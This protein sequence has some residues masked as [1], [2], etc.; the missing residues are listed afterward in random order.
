[1]DSL[2][3][4]KIREYAEE[5]F[6][7]TDFKA[8]I[9]KGHLI[10]SPF[11]KRVCASIKKDLETKFPDKV[12]QLPKDSMFQRSIKAALQNGSTKV[13]PIKLTFEDKPRAARGQKR[14]I[15][16]SSSEEDEAS[17][18]AST[19]DQ[20]ESP[21]P[22]SSQESSPVTRS[23]AP[24]LEE[25]AA[26]RLE[27]EQLRGERDALQAKVDKFMDL[28]LVRRLPTR[29]NSG[30]AETFGP[31]LQAIALEPMATGAAAK[32]VREVLFSVARHLDML[33]DE[34]YRV[35]QL[36]WFTRLRAKQDGLLAKQREQFLAPERGRP[37]PS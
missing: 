17:P 29:G 28:F 4:A 19:S 32:H 33:P 1:M 25:N 7:G 22:G 36:N 35:P 34:N 24:L 6:T 15:V 18:S 13:R 30:S 5:I 3:S 27:V 12:V 9:R 16:E 11:V 8:A 14:P 31:A 2:D 23:T 37:D 20:V 10:E 26:L 21:V